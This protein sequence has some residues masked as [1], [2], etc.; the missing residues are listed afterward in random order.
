[1]VLG[2]HSIKNGNNFES[3][4]NLNIMCLR[5]IFHC[6][7]MIHLNETQLVLLKDLLKTLCSRTVNNENLSAKKEL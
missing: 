3:G 1:M 4:V 7:K 5:M 6:A 2:S